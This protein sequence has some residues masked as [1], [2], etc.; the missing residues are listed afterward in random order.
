VTI[1]APSEDAR[2]W[3]RG[4]AR[5]SAVILFAALVYAGVRVLTEGNR[6]EAEA[7]GRRL[8]D[9]ERALHLDWEAALQSPVLAHRWLTTLVNWDYI[10]GFWP[11][12]AGSAVLLYARH[13]DEYALLRNSI[14]LSGLIGFAFFALLPVAPPRLVDPQLTD[15]IRRGAGWYRTVQPLDLTNQY[16]AMPSLHFGWS[17]LVGHA[18]WRAGRRAAAYAF[19]VLM[20]AAMAFAVVAT[21][22]HY[23]V[24]VLVGGI[25]AALALALASRL[26]R[27][28]VRSS[29]RSGRRLVRS[30]DVAGTRAGGPS[31]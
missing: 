18:V 4:A 22:N 1:P 10:W 30:T 12:L 13:R 16:A 28:V 20:P 7:N 8:L 2:S 26:D 14:F 21:A 5:E 15:T 24:D 25:V 31:R 23:V 19:A 11:V 6:H 17:L 3:V 29:G 27:T 9:L